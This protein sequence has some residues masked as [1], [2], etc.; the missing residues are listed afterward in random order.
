MDSTLGLRVEQLDPQIAPVFLLEPPGWTRLEPQSVSG[1]PLP[2]L[3]A[4]VHDPLWLLTRQWQLGEFHG[5]D[6]GSPLSVTIALTVAPVIGFQAGDPG[7]AFPARPWLQ[8]E[9]L[10]PVVEREPTPDRSPGLRQRAEAGAQLLA[11]LTEVGV[12]GDALDQITAACTLALP[13]PDDRDR[14]APTLLGLLSGRLPDG[15]KAAVEIAAALAGSPPA[16]PSWFDGVGNEATVMAAVQRW[17]AWYRGSVSPLPDAASESWIN[18]RLEYRFSLATAAAN[19]QRVLRAPSFGG[20]RADWFDVDHDP[21]AAPLALEGPT[22]APEQRSS[23]LLAAPLRFAGMPADR[24]WEFE[25]GSVNLGALQVQPHD[26]ARLALVEFAMVYGSDWLV[27]P[28]DVPYGSL[29]TINSVTCATTFGEQVTVPSVDDT[30]RSGLFRLFEITEPGTTGSLRAL[31]IPPAAPAVIEG[32]AIEEVLFTRD[33]MANMAWAIERVVQGPSGDART[34]GDEPPPAPFAPPARTQVR[35][36]TTC[37][38]TRC[39]TA[40]SRCCRCRPAT[41]RSRCGRA[42]W[43]RTA[44]PSSPSGCC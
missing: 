16:L 29:V 19:G 10:E 8:G 7:T 14:V 22:A 39:R 32:P 21:G 42:P 17:Y 26:L 9:L 12:P 38:R 15:E 11:D 43:S 25:D 31:F 27:L 13:W 5:E 3:E 20:G 30:S 41:P 1:D 36:W 34:R 28:L 40:G 33:E 2:G 35:T 18:D 6:V 4:R 37:S 23:T 24:Y 44:S